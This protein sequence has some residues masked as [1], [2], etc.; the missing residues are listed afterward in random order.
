MFD[1]DEHC[2]SLVGDSSNANVT[3]V[4]VASVNYVNVT[5]NPGYYMKSAVTSALVAC[6]CGEDYAGSDFED[7]YGYCAGM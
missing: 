6:E 1:L 2:I 7:I 3:L 5:C 4:T